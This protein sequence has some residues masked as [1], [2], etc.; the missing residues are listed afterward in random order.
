V[1]DA[2]IV[3]FDGHSNAAGCYTKAIFPLAPGITISRSND[4]LHTNVSGGT[5]NAAIPNDTKTY[6]CTADIANGVID[7]LVNCAINKGH[8]S[9]YGGFTLGLKNHF[10]TFAP[11]HNTNYLFNMNMSDAILGG[12]PP[13]QQLCIIDSLWGAINGPGSLPEAK[14]WNPLARITMGTLS[15]IVDYLTAKE[16]REKLMG[17]TNH[18]QTVLKRFL[19][20]FGYAESDPKWVEISGEGPITGASKFGLG[21]HGE[22]ILELS[23]AGAPSVSFALPSAARRLSLEILNPTGRLIRRYN[24]T[25]VQSQRVLFRWDGTSESGRAAA[26][27]MYTV[28]VAAED[29]QAAGMIA[30]RR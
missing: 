26:A 25:R 11:V 12:T 30:L 23:T 28:R 3:V 20:D 29:V 21:S 10:G 5:V 15:P 14:T 8:G 17:V 13:R 16:I 18:N 24:A 9:E 7:I 4:S 1:P 22:L 6:A 2:S 19:T 27:G